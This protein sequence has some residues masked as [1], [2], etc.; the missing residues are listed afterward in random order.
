MIIYF[1]V[2]LEIYKVRAEIRALE[3]ST[4]F[5]PLDI[6][7][8]TQ[9][10]VTLTSTTLIST[11]NESRKD[12]HNSYALFEAS[13]LVEEGHCPGENHERQDENESADEI[14]SLD[15]EVENRGMNYHRQYSKPRNSLSQANANPSHKITS[16]LDPTY[17][18][19]PAQ[20]NPPTSPSR[21]PQRTTM[22]RVK[23]AYTKCALL[24]GISILITWVPASANR[25]HGILNGTKPSFV[26]NVLS[27]IVLPLQ[28]FWNTV[29]FFSTSEFACP[30]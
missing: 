18:L 1:F 11:S 8:A 12:S 20:T 29:I 26:L 5:T 7:S 3:D 15:S 23:W 13:T 14:C 21:S 2:G 6:N 28:G 27:A 10:S 25:I 19:C 24:F 17:N 22:D 9:N 30:Y 4:V 16:P